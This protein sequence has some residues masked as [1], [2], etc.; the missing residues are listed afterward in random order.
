MAT[1]MQCNGLT[2]PTWINVTNVVEQ[3]DVICTTISWDAP[4]GGMEFYTLYYANVGG[5][6]DNK[7]LESITTSYTFKDG[8]EM[9]IVAHRNN[10]KECSPGMY[11]CNYPLALYLSPRQHLIATGDWRW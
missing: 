6:C 1:T 3:D 10:M 7:T 9:Q 4:C 8:H 5:E 11:S 2:A